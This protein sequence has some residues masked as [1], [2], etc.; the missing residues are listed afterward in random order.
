MINEVT[1]DI[2]NNEHAY[3]L[4][5]VNKTTNEIICLECI[6]KMDVSEYNNYVT[7]YYMEGDNL[8]CDECNE[9]IESA[10]GPIE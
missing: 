8:Q 4:I 5:F 3:P 9:I 2:I 7:E 6:R 10:Y 1:N